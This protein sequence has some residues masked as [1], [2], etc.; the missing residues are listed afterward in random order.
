MFQGASQPI[1][2]AGRVAQVG[3]ADLR[4]HRIRPPTLRC[5]DRA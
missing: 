3:F 5:L 2:G 4:T 1:D